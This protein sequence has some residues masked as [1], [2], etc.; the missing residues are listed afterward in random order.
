MQ[1]DIKMKAGNS[2]NAITIN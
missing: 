1:K 2:Y